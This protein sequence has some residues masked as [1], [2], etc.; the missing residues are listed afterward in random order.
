MTKGISFLGVDPNGDLPE[1]L[2]SLAYDPIWDNMV[3]LRASCDCGWR[4]SEVYFRFDFAD[5]E[6]AERQL[7]E[8]HRNKCPACQ[9][10]LQY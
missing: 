9:N 8:L 1:D 7:V 5:K 6:R 10:T 2:L 3:C 4:G